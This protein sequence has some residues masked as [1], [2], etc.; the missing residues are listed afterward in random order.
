MKKIEAFENALANQ[1]DLRE[2][3]INSTVFWAYRDSQEAE[4][5]T[6]NFS[7]VIWEKD[8]PAIVECCRENDVHE[9]TI[10]STFSGLLET[11]AEFE[12]MG[13]KLA[14]LTTVKTRF[15]DFLTGEKEVRPAVM[16]KL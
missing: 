13:C 11:L 15:T 4:S 14:G 6:L 2:V 8:I 5:D 7:E 10:S 12:K 16:M 9:F 1:V 3:G